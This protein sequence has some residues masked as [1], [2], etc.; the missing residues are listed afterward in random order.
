MTDA[1][2]APYYR[3]ED[4]RSRPALLRAHGRRYATL[5]SPCGPLLNAPSLMRRPGHDVPHRRR[6][7]HAPRA[8]GRRDAPRGRAQR[9]VLRGGRRRVWPS[10]RVSD[11]DARGAGHVQ[12]VRTILGAGLLRGPL[13]AGYRDRTAGPAS[14]A[15]TQGSRRRP[16]VTGTHL[17]VAGTSRRRSASS[18]SSAGSRPRGS[19]TTPPPY[20]PAL[21]ALPTP[22]PDARMRAGAPQYMQEFPD[23][24]NQN[25]GPT[26]QSL[27]ALLCDV[28]WN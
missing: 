7:P 25:L 11:D 14:V 3:D 26:V 22:A 23:F 27:C 9:R 19:S 20:A 17:S 21:C 12:H 2:M 5:P 24:V 4:R 15:C 10:R 18:T 6:A 8:P 16:A 28:R 1:T 13:C